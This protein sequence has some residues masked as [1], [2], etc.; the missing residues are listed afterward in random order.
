M[1]RIFLRAFS[2]F[3]S[4]LWVFTVFS[5]TSCSHK[6]TVSEL[7]YYRTREVTAEITLECGGTSSGFHYSGGASD[8]TIE[9]TYPEELCG[10]SLQLTESGGRVSIGELTAEAPDALCTVPKI[11]LS[12]FTLSPEEITEISAAPHPE[13]EGETV[14]TITADGI[15]VTL[16]SSGLPLL[17]EGVLFGVS[18]TAKIADFTVEPRESDGISE[19][20]LEASK[21]SALP[22]QREE[23]F[24]DTQR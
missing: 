5:A 4:I 3:F 11:M 21:E 7:F 12:V 1:Y 18:F 23:A 14:T 24:S 19:Q 6:T 20:L 13:R 2:L 9:F 8:C 16:D 17:A 22:P 15:R 10:Y